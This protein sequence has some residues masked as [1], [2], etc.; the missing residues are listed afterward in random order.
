MVTPNLCSRATRTPVSLTFPFYRPPGQTVDLH[1]HRYPVELVCMGT[2]SRLRRSDLGCSQ[3]V[4]ESLCDGQWR[5][6]CANLEVRLPFSVSRCSRRPALFPAPVLSVLFAL[7]VPLG[8]VHHRVR[9]LCCHLLFSPSS[10]CP[11]TSRLALVSSALCSASPTPLDRPALGLSFIQ[12]GHCL[13]P[14]AIFSR[15]R[16]AAP[17]SGAR[18]GARY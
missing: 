18:I 16:L 9:A 11:H 12:A 6:A 5:Y 7:P 3:S 2:D 1:G 8:L 10:S 15:T 13:P 14:L 17:R 4:R